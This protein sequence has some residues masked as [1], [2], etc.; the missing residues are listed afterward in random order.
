MIVLKF[1][2]IGDNELQS[3]YHERLTSLIVKTLT[4]SF[5]VLSNC[6]QNLMDLFYDAWRR[7]FNLFERFGDQL[8]N[9]NQKEVEAVHYI[10]LYAK[11]VLKN[12]FVYVETSDA[13]LL[14]RQLL[15]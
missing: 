12:D 2:N 10:K 1:E 7:N 5:G 6:K 8:S 13:N 9:H 15:I 3:I 11:G 14:T 4:R